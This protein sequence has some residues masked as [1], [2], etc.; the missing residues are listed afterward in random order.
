M[1][2]NLL[3]ILAIAFMN[4]A[5]MNAQKAGYEVKMNIKGLSDATLKMAYY[6]GDK[7]YVKDSARVD[8]KGNA[9]F[10]GDESLPAGIYIAVLPNLNYF[11]F[12]MDKEQRFSLETDTANLIKNMKV[13]GNKDNE[14][15]YEY[16]K[17]ASEKGK[18][19]E[20]LRKELEANKGNKE[21]TESITAR[22]KALDE[23]MKVFKLNFINK[24]RDRFLSKV[25]LASY[26]PEAP[27][28]PILANGRKDSLFTFNYIKKHYLDS[29]DFKDDRLLRTPVLGNKVKNYMERIVPQIPD[30]IIKAADE[31]IART[32]PKS[33]IFKYLVYYIT[34]TYEKSKLMGMDAVFVHMAKNYYLTDKVYWIEDHQ[35]QKIME[36]VLNL[37]DNLIGKTAV[38]LKLLTPEFHQTELH[39]INK[40]FTI[41][42]FWDPSCGH[43]KKVTPKLYEFY[44]EKKDTYNLEVFAVYSEAD[45]AEWLGY[46]R[47]N[48]Y[49]W[50]NAADLLWKT[51]FKLHYDIYATPVIYIL[52]RNKKIIAKRLDVENIEDFLKNYVKNNKQKG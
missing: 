28:A 52:D 16:M 26:D 42:Y 41:V 30:S 14:L 23:E 9:V 27:E 35:R 45:T 11:E 6:F 36:R 10:R 46:L 31:I 47:K 3:L 24:N 21:L 48:D 8:S 49:Q 1:K 40:E 13:K 20:N 34:N 4:C 43:C 17:F 22:Q 44:Q 37:Q 50:I 19:M 39:K 33:E 2:R 32:D 7:Q 5:Q 38:N 29:V 12:I 18:E 15:F 51:N 25:F